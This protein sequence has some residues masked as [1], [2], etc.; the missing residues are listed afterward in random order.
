MSSVARQIL[1][2][3]NKALAENLKNQFIIFLDHT[4]QKSFIAMAQK[5]NWSNAAEVF[6]IEFG[7]LWNNMAVPRTMKKID[8]VKD[9]FANLLLVNIKQKL[10][11]DTLVF[12]KSL[13]SANQLKEKDLS[14][15]LNEFF[16][17]AMY[18]LFRVFDYQITLSSLS[19][20]NDAKYMLKKL[21]DLRK[22]E[23]HVVKMASD[24]DQSEKELKVFQMIDKELDR[25]ERV[26]QRWSARAACDYYGKNELGYGEDN[27]NQAELD[28]FFARYQIYR[29]KSKPRK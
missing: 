14:S 2:E 5:I 7:K 9:D 25:R 21:D 22:R 17:S 15:E 12:L 18:E 13:G 24:D 29:Q 8:E 11:Y 10:F 28:H 6:Q 16:Y 26:G 1:L 3:M 20:N 23:I 27:K 19:K 4:D